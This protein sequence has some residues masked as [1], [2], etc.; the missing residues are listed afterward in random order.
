MLGTTALYKYK[1]STGE[2]K[3]M[4]GYFDQRSRLRRL[5]RYVMKDGKV[6]DELSQT[7]LGEGPELLAVRR[8]LTF[9]NTRT[10]LTPSGW[11]GH[12]RP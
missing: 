12:G 5:A 3:V 6:F 8:L 11:L 4:A 10:E 9:P 1:S 7:E 2:D